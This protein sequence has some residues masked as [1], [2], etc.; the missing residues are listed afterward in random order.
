MG[1]D[2]GGLIYFKKRPSDLEWEERMRKIQGTG[3]PPYAEWFCSEHYE[4]A[5]ELSR[6]TIDDALN[7]L[8][9]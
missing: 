6:L 2:D 4:K 9:L 8:K 3:H 1:I 5:K 7:K